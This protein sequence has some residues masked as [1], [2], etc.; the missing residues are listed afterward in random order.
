MYLSM[1]NYDGILTAAPVSQYSYVP[2]KQYCSD[3]SPDIQG[4]A[5]QLNK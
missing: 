4:C 5:V 1:G 3:T 2:E